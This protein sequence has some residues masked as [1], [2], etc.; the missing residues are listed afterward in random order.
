MKWKDLKGKTDKELTSLLIQEREN[1][2]KMR[3]QITAGQLTNTSQVKKT[4]RI[5]ARIL[6][7]LKE[8]HA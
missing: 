1:L 5:I 7:L 6:T 3:F 8:K 4:K 2:R